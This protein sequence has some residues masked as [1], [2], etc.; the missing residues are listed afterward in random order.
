M[1]AEHCHYTTLAAIDAS[2]ELVRYSGAVL[3]SS[4]AIKPRT[5]PVCALKAEPGVQKVIML[6]LARTQLYMGQRTLFTF[7]C[8]GKAF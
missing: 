4:N 2:N 5:N 6:M 7:M 1:A 8:A 3:Y